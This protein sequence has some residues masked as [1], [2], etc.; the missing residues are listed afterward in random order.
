MLNLLSNSRKEFFLFTCLIL[1]APG[2]EKVS[3]YSFTEKFKNITNGYSSLSESLDS[4]PT[5]WE[6]P[7]GPGYLPVKALRDE[8]YAHWDHSWSGGMLQ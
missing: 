8:A 7:F 6:Q 4:Y 2:D 5:C 3:H 1:D